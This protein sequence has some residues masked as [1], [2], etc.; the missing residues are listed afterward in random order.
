MAEALLQAAATLRRELARFDPSLV[1]GQDCVAVVEQLAATG[2]ACA[3]A[4]ARAAV[5]VAACHAHGGRGYRDPADWL[6]RAGG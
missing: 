4:E 2:K 6:A 1:S 3:A 5:R